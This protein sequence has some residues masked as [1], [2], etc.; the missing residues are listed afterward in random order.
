MLKLAGR[1]ISTDQEITV[2]EGARHIDFVDPDFLN[3]PGH[4][5]AIVR[6]LHREFPDL[7]F[8][9]TAKV[10]H[11]L[12]RRGILKELADSG[13]LF[14]VTAVE[15]LSDRVL[16]ELDK[17]H[18]RADVF[19]VL[20]ATRRA[21]IGLRPTFVPFTPWTT[22][23]DHRELLQWI[24]EERLVDHVDPVQLALRLLVPPGSLLLGT[25]ALSPHMGSL[26]QEALTYRWEH[27]DPEM[28]RLQRAS[29][30]LIENAM[31]E[32]WSHRQTLAGLAELAGAALPELGTQQ[33]TP[34]LTEAWFC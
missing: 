3:G 33:P 16:G 12:R 6:A 22:L 8:D 18:S 25:P 19:E 26:D 27:P 32:G 13:C 11:L 9:F 15:S 10:E 34:R 21:G 20:D 23:G 29:Q 31:G 14:I 30:K 1:K 7:T 4:A 17:G 28:D 2:R 24:A 5:L